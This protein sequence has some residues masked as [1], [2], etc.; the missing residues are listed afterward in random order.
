MKKTFSLFRLSLCLIALISLI[1]V[2]VNVSAQSPNNSIVGSLQ[3]AFAEAP[4][5]AANSVTGTITVECW[6][7]PGELNRRQVLVSK[8]NATQGGYELYIDVDNRV[9]FATYGAAGNLKMNFKVASP[10][11][12]VGTWYHIAGEYSTAGL[13]GI[14][15]GFCNGTGTIN[16]TSASANEGPGSGTSKLLMMKKATGTGDF[17]TGRLDEVRISNYYRYPGIVN[18]I[19]SYSPVQSF[20]TDFFTKA[21]YRMNEPDTTNVINDSSSV[22]NPGTYNPG[23]AGGRLPGVCQ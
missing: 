23:G 3:Q 2:S 9:G 6:A 4:S 18:Q 7:Q 1:G 22:A 19:V 10:T 21:L 17:F 16:S 12:T 8:H 5:T 14:A 20:S 13:V 15:V 11:L